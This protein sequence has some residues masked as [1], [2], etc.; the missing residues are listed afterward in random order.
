MKAI[1]LMAL[2]LISANCYT[3]W[4]SW[5]G[6]PS[7]WSPSLSNAQNNTWG[8]SG[9]TKNSI[10]NQHYSGNFN[11]YTQ[12]YTQY[13]YWKNSNPDILI[14][15]GPKYYLYSVDFCRVNPY[16][17]ASGMNE[18]CIPNYFGYSGKANWC[19]AKSV[20]YG[21]NIK[22]CYGNQSGQGWTFETDIN[23]LDP[24]STPI[25]WFLVPKTKQTTTIVVYLFIF[26]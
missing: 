16:Y 20:G 10:T 5:H 9:W 18:Y 24:Y 22:C 23:S 17:K 1:F 11:N 26:L 8:L 3:I 12:I 15:C 14:M 2:I 6:T 19:T 25:F 21:P 13:L 7:A 4:D